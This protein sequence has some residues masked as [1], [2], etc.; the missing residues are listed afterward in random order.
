MNGQ[1]R[2][3]L[4]EAYAVSRSLVERDHWDRF[5][6]IY[7]SQSAKP[8]D[9]PGIMA[10][11]GGDS[12]FP[13]FLPEL[14]R[15]EW[16]VHETGST[17][18]PEHPPAN[19]TSLNPTLYLLRLPWKH[20]TNLLH[21]KSDAER[22]NGHLYCT[23][24][25][26][27]EPEQGEEFVL[28]W[29]QPKSG[30]VVV[31][32]AS[33]EDLLVLKIVAEDI[34]RRKAAAEGRVSVFAIDAAIDRAAEKGLLIAPPSGIRRDRPVSSHAA[35]SMYEAVDQDAAAASVF[36]LQ[37]HITQACD[38]HCRHCYDRSDKNLLD[39]SQ[40]IAILD[41]L[42]NFCRQRHVRG[43]ISFSGGNPFLHPRFLDLYRAGAERGFG[44]AI[45]GNPMPRKRLEEV[46]AIEHP[47]FYQVSLEG[48]PEHNDWTRG[49]EHFNRTLEFLDILR[50]LGIYSM[51]MLTLTR[52][53]MAQV[54]PLAEMLRDRTD[55][56]TFNRLSQVGE[57][58]NLQLPSREDY[59]T[60][61]EAYLDAAGKNPVMA[62]K[63]NLINIVLHQ[64]GL[65]PFEGCTGF[66]CGA[67]FNFVTVLP[68]GEVHACRKFP[69][70]IGNIT[71]ESLAEVYE[72]KAARA[73]RAGCSACSGC[74]IRNVCGGC[75][76]V[77]YGSGR[78]PL[79]EMDP[80]CFMGYQQTI[81][82]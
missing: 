55:L 67:A 27:L 58:A 73:Y 64:K 60:F 6:E 28:A 9:L 36:T 69:S 74:A 33:S 41:D 56:F 50:D 53:N 23:H 47:V 4:D 10:A 79:T 15:L 16:A 29:R 71:H 80:L 2:N 18:I 34:D 5:L 59:K 39:H 17:R 62:L 1:E 78:D 65:Q 35:S 31:R 32:P 20:L 81:R 11:L 22:D 7:D 57:G 45:L 51:V 13:P 77:A 42:Y 26:S 82:G 8:P 72:S 3:L 37:W 66:G 46:I 61:L 14:A 43:Q 76:A 38:L 40:A 44:L 25:S 19:R 30:A 48:L 12:T 63:D 75:L 21:L 54:I 52:D 70:R 68:D 24:H 49:P